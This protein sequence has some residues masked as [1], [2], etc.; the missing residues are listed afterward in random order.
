[1]RKLKKPLVLEYLQ[2]NGSITSLIAF[3]KFKATRLSS[4]ILRLRREGHNIIT[5]MEED[6]ENGSTYA[7]YVYKGMWKDGVA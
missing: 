5:V 4:I 3:D 2:T 6:K 1:M 7:R